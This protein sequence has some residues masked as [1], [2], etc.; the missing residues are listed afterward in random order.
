M[1]KALCGDRFYGTHTC[2]VPCVN[3][4]A[5]AFRSK[6]AHPRSYRLLPEHAE[7][8][9]QVRAVAT[10]TELGIELLRRYPPPMLQRYLHLMDMEQHLVA[11]RHNS[12]HDGPSYR[13]PTCDDCMHMDTVHLHMQG[14]AA[15]EWMAAIFPAYDPDSSGMAD[16]LV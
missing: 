12:S 16:T 8:A 15:A 14:H 5:D 6:L 1:H 3:R 4:A 11:T 7:G 2:S 9:A 10:A 13:C